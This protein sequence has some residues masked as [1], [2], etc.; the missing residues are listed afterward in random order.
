[1]A[2]GQGKRVYEDI[3][4]EGHLVDSNILARIMSG[5]VEL[6]GEFEV[7]SFQIGRGNENPSTMS[8]RVYGRDGSHLTELLRML[9]SLGVVPAHPGD[10]SVEP[11]PADGVFPEGFYATTNL[12]TLVR[13]DGRWTEVEG[14][15]MDLGVRV[16]RDE[17]AAAG[18]PLSQVRK[19]D[20]FV[21]GQGGI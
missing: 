1:M 5:I 21:V 14:T 15:E 19:G 8:M 11:A 2:E 4:A 20:L 17:Q 13:I 9:H 3:Q 7:L 18:V 12:E 10:V 16:D 6:D